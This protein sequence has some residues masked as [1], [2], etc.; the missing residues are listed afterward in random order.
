MQA[1]GIIQSFIQQAETKGVKTLAEL[2][3]LLPGPTPDIPLVFG[4]NTSCSEIFHNNKRFFV[5]MG[6]GITEA[7]HHAIAKGE[8]EFVI[9]QTH[10][11]WDHIMGLPFFVPVY[12]PG[13]KVT[14]YHV[15]RN[16]PEFIK[17]QFNGVNFPVKWE[18]LGATI[19]FKLLKPYQPTIINDVTIT[20]FTLDHP[21]G[22]FGYRFDAAGKSLAIGVDG[23]YKRLTPQELGPDLKFYQNLDV[24]V[25]D[26]QYE[27]DELA[28]RFD[29][30]H[31]SPPI[32]VDLALREGIRNL[33][34][35]HHDPRSTEEKA[36]R[37]REHAVH[38]AKAELANHRELWTKIKQPEGPNIRSAYDGLEMDLHGPS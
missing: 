28:S 5:D 13:N 4:G 26:A 38:Y 6:T 21:G 20:P 17:L 10:M 11:H 22:S 16:A 34:L 27:M 31:C 14:I 7:G 19:E 1:V 23:E 32:G 8:K 37:M 36:H 33:I 29:W 24:L 18:E 15:H 2:V 30:G 9:F 12:I 3:K 35:T 25:F